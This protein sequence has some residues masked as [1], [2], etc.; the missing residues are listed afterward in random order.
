MLGEDATDSR[1]SVPFGLKFQDWQLMVRGLAQKGANS[2]PVSSDELST[3]TAIHAKKIAANLGFLKN[4]GVC[5][6]ESKGSSIMLTDKGLAYANALVMQDKNKQDEL[7]TEF[8]KSGLKQVIEFCDLHRQSG[9]LSYPDLFNHIKLIAGLSEKPSAVWGVDTNYRYGIEIVIEMLVISK[10]LDETFLPTNNKEPPQTKEKSPMSVIT[11]RRKDY[12]VPTRFQHTWIERLFKAIR[13]VNPEIIN[14]NFIGASVE[15]NNHEGS[16][17]KICKF[18]DISKDDDKRGDNYEKLRYFGTNDFK[19]NLGEII[20]QKYSRILQYVNL[21]GDTA[22]RENL[23]ATFMREYDMDG[24]S[25][26]GAVDFLLDL[27]TFSDIELANNLAIKSK[28][29]AI[30]VQSVPEP[31]TPKIEQHTSPT[32]RPNLIPTSIPTL[33]MG[34]NGLEIK[35]NVTID[36]KESQAFANTL[37]FI[38]ALRTMSDKPLELEEKVATSSN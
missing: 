29:S 28:G 2:R 33:T 10:V 30:K 25:A 21:Q 3:L 16:I 31:K 36:A 24:A 14:R 18:L 35:I 26:E 38:K 34:V 11:K 7:I 37:D 5:T 13:D 22:K 12:E 23:V 1:F 20:R 32:T 15:G 6:L 8:V 17:L 9:D 27:C 19:K 4:L